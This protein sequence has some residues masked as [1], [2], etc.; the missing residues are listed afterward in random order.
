VYNDNLIE[1]IQKIDHQLFEQYLDKNKSNLRMQEDFHSVEFDYSWVTKIEESIEFLDTIV[2]NPRRFIV[3]E[4]EIVPIEKA[5][6]ISLETIKH[7]AQHTNLI[8]DVD[9][10]GTVT[11]SSVLNVHK[12]ESFDIYENRFIYS[13]LINLRNFIRMRKEVI[14]AGSSSNRE[15]KLSYSGEAKIDEEKI[16]ITINLETKKLE[17]L[18]KM[19]T[20]GLDVNTR[21][22]RVE[23][24]INDF[25]H[26][27]FMKEMLNAIMVRSPIRKTNVILKNQNFKKAL[28]LWEFIE[29]YDVTS[30]NEKKYQK[31]IKD[32]LNIEEKLGLISCLNY[33]ILNTGAEKNGK[34][35]DLLNNYQIR[36]IVNDFVKNNDFINEKE[37]KKLLTRTFKTAKKKRQLEDKQIV[38]VLNASTYAYKKSIEKGL[39]LLNSVS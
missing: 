19:N 30:K 2:R 20:G 14:G 6:R 7:L 25:F 13:L 18:I 23:L 3:Q 10:E 16:K 28:E 26:S 39:K 15:R 1:L 9:E 27:S 22:E 32:R 34:V 29:H 33:F 17:K 35:K 4:E 31:E 21:I 24:I 5:K 36:K 8:Q 38:K 12:E 37:L 11:P